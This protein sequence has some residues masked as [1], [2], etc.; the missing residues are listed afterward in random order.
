MQTTTHPI[1]STSTYYLSCLFLVASLLSACASPKPVAVLKTN[2]V[3]PTARLPGAM[4]NQITVEDMRSTADLMARDLVLQP[5]ISRASKPPVIA[6]KPIENKSDLIIDP[7]IFQKTIRVHLMEQAGGR[8]LFRDEVAHQYTLDERMKQTGTLQISSITTQQRVQQPT[9]I[10]QP[11]QT[12]TQSQTKTVT[13]EAGEVTKRVADVN[14]FLT[15]LIYSSKEVVASGAAKGMRYFQF[16]FRVTDAQ[17]NIIVW[18]KE[19]L[20]K[21]QGSFQ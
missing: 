14:Y 7:D 11:I 3:A 9:R 19:Y 21:R 10:G 1:R 12:I 20:V 15:G 17:T 4:L 16:Q 6:V 5:F 8:V 2:R 18:E 13:R